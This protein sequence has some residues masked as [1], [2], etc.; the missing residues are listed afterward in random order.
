MWSW[1]VLPNLLSHF[2]VGRLVIWQQCWQRVVP[3]VVTATLIYMLIEIIQLCGSDPRIS[4]GCDYPL[5]VSAQ[6]KC[7]MGH[8]IGRMGHVSVEGQFG[9][10]HIS[11]F[12]W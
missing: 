4:T 7:S 1:E 5:I 6:K 11:W 9:T 8:H 2:A 12:S 10:Q 3:M